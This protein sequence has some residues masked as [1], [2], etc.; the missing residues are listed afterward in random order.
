L[1]LPETPLPVEMMKLEPF[2]SRDEVILAPALRCPIAPTGKES[3]QH[4]QVDRSFDVKPILT[5]H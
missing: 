2:G 1:G 4:R 5:S 3:V